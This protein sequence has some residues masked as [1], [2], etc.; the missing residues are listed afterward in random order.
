V[1]ASLL[2]W[3]LLVWPLLV[4]VVARDAGQRNVKTRQPQK[5]HRHKHRQ[6]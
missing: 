4:L 3:V 2:W 5:H 6:Q 1:A